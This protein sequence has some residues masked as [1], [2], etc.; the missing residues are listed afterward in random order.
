MR[1][2]ANADQT[3][4]Y[5]DM[6]IGYAA[7]EKGAKEVKQRTAS[8]E[9]QQATVMRKML[10]SHDSFSPDIIVCANEKGSRTSDN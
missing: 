8:Y 1:Q 6:L 2:I 7:K 5:F 4:A 9:K 10:S 3:T